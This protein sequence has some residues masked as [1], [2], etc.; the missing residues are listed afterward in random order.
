M[1]E[2]RVNKKGTKGSHEKISNEKVC[3]NSCK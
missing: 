2:T 1:M 3:A